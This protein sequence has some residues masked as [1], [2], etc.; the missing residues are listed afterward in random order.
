MEGRE[1]ERAHLQVAIARSMRARREVE[2]LRQAHGLL[3]EVAIHF[4][5]LAQEDLAALEKV[6]EAS[7]AVPADQDQGRAAMTVLAQRLGGRPRVLVV[8]GNERQ[9]KHH[10]RLQELAEAWGFDAEW[11]MT[12]YKIGRAHV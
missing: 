11:V 10:P 2:S 1:F 12:N 9:R 6:L 3:Q 8:G 5:E 4:P 7:D